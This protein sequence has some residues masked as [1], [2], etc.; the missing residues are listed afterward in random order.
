MKKFVTFLLAVVLMLSLAGCDLFSKADTV[1][2]GDYTH[3]DP[4][5]LSYDTRL[6]LKNGS[7]GAMLSEN[8]SVDAT[9]TT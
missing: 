5:G 1:K 9:P 6:V 4:S 7:F 2:L 3:K 8:A